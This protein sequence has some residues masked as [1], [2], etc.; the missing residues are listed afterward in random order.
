MAEFEKGQFFFD[1]TATNYQGSKGKY[2]IGLTD[3]ND[4]DDIIVSFVLNTENNFQKYNLNCNRDIQKYILTPNQFSFL[5][6]YTSI[7]LSVPR[8]YTFEEMCESHIDILKDIADEKV[9]RQ[10]KNC[11][12]MDLIEPIFANPIKECFKT[13]AKNKS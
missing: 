6:N 11:I 12:D 4:G 2:F 9:C 10:I 8:K 13:T 7:M 3:A 1:K 5:K